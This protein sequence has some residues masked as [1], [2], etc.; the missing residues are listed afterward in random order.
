MQNLHD[1]VLGGGITSTKGLL[2]VWYD[3][4]WPKLAA[5]SP[6]SAD[7]PYLMKD[8]LTDFET[9]VANVL[10]VYNSC[11]PLLTATA[12]SRCHFSRP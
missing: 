5:F 2:Q 7:T 1:C 10:L 3:E 8:F 6:T 11:Q 9:R 4:L 12:F